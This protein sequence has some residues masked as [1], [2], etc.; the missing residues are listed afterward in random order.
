[1]HFFIVFCLMLLAGPSLANEPVAPPA[2][3]TPSM[4][5]PATPKP[6]A[7]T[8]HKMGVV[9]V[10]R[11]MQEAS[12]AKMV[13]QQL[14]DQ[15]LKFQTII[16]DEEKELRQAEQDLAK[17]RETAKPDLYAEKEQLLR[18]K[19]VA[20]ERRVQARRKVL[21]TAFTESMETVKK[22]LLE[23]VEAVALDKNIQVMLLK[24]QILWNAKEL[25][26]TDEILR[27][28]DKKLPSIDIKIS[29]QDMLNPPDKG[30]SM[31]I[32]KP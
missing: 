1:M 4:S 23:I 29:E 16:A 27:R 5:S 9:D 30:P 32:Q 28:L 12:S 3:P 13:Q 26:L 7:P 21:D 20:V 18:Q 24:Q 22:N 14:E 8:I 19:F 2:A 6:D 25:D 17:E 10:Q 15:R 31:L 11:V